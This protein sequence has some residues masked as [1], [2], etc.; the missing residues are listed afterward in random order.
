MI[1]IGMEQEL[2]KKVFKSPQWLRNLKSKYYP[3]WRIDTLFYK[4]RVRSA[5]FID[6]DAGWHFSYLNTPEQIKNN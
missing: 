5:K 1:L 3:Y 6:D 4:N 2:A